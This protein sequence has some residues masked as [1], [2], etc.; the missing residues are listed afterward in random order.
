MAFFRWIEEKKNISIHVKNS[1]NSIRFEQ[2]FDTV[3]YVGQFML[4][5]NWANVWFSQKC[6]AIS[7]NHQSKLMRASA[8]TYVQYKHPYSRFFQPTNYENY[9]C[10][11]LIAIIFN[12]YKARQFT[13]RRRKKQQ[14]AW[15]SNNF[16][17]NIPNS[18]KWFLRCRYYACR[19][20]HV[21]R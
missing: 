17:W 11:R 5:T 1:L 12:F 13:N 14:I 8:Q 18:A 9:R 3:P 6:A 4:S 20:N 10:K 16:E 7:Y 2:K 15:K 21:Q 19:Q